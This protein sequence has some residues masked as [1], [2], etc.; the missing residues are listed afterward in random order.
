MFFYFLLFLVTESEVNCVT[1]CIVP[2][3][4]R[5]TIFSSVLRFC[6][7]LRRTWKAPNSAAFLLF[8]YFNSWGHVTCNL[9]AV[10]VQGLSEQNNSPLFLTANSWIQADSYAAESRYYVPQGVEHINTFELHNIKTVDWIISLIQVDK[11]IAGK[12]KELRQEMVF[13][14]TLPLFIS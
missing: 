11:M 14:P 13:V 4:S 12:M 9:S 7:S 1:V 10:S 8:F 6:L 2:Q 3:P 5:W